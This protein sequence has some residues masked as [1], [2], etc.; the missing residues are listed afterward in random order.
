LKNKLIFIAYNQRDKVLA[1][2]IYRYLLRKNWADLD[3]FID[4]VSVRTGLNFGEEC[5][6]ASES[7]ELGIVVLSEYSQKSSYVPQEIGLLLARRI[8]KIYVALHEEWKV[9]PGYENSIKSFPMY[10]FR[11]PSDGLRALAD[12]VQEYLNPGSLGAVELN[13]LAVNAREQG[14]HQR[15]LDLCDRAIEADP[16]YEYPYINKISNLR[17][18]GRYQEAL[19]FADTTIS[20]FP[21]SHMAFSRKAF[22]YFSTQRNEEAIATY[23]AALALSPRSSSDLYYKGRSLE[24]LEKYDKALECYWMIIENDPQSKAGRRAKIRI[25]DLEDRRA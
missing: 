21:R 8:P 16:E 19:E 18:L 15:S 12:L 4:E 14:D 7:A 25:E 24:N 23:D 5:I 6:K 17:F 11:D 13:S 10:E 3:I 20:K 1:R 2:F 9:P 22:V